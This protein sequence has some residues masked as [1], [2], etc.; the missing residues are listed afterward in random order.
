MKA[1]KLKGG[2]GE[3][4]EVSA[5]SPGVTEVVVDVAAVG[6]S[7]A[8]LAAAGSG[9]TPGRFFAGS[10]AAIGP[11]VAGF[12]IGDTVVAAP[13]GACGMC[14]ACL[15][16]DDAYC[17]RADVLYGGIRPGVDVDGGAAQQVC[18]DAS[19][20]ALAPN[21]DLAVAALASDVGVHSLHAVRSAGD[22]I[23][24]GNTVA[25]LGA[26]V[27]AAYTAALLEATTGVEVLRISDYSA[28]NQQRLLTEFAYDGIPASLVMDRTQEACDFAVEITAMGGA[29]VLAN[30]GSGEVLVTP[31]PATRYEVAVRAVEYGNRA[32]LIELLKLLQLQAVEIEDHR[33]CL[34]EFASFDSQRLREIEPGLI[35]VI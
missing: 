16:G 31:V 33:V 24:A 2:S 11:A 21:L 5:P 30:N 34:D 25:V 19:F 27:L 14:G 23:T 10:I 6:M 13:P 17:A 35:V 22:T 15:R 20:L 9:V 32:D 7:A 18:V 26:G 29:I 8:D 4:V 28:E 3:L 12:Q 1:L